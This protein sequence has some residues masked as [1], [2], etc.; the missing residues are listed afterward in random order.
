MKNKKYA[1]KD[2]IIRING[3]EW[4]KL[5]EGKKYF[6]VAKDGRVARYSEYLEDGSIV[7]YKSRISNRGYVLVDDKLVHRLV[8]K[9]WLSNP[10]LM[11]TIDHIDADKTN[12]HISNLQWLSRKD[13]ARK[14]VYVEGKQIGKAPKQITVNGELYISM[15]EAARVL[16]V[17]VGTISGLAKRAGS[18][19]I[20]YG[21]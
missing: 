2:P 4:Y 9:A 19:E 7:L 10:Y 11:E 20:T 21:I 13:N 18:M 5:K 16:G 14:A 1:H 15:S 12:N 6:L 17:N 8:A 3:V